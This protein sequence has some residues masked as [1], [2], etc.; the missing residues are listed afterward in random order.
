MEEKALNT[1]GINRITDAEL[2]E[3]A[4]EMTKFSYAPYSK[5]TVGTAL[6]AADGTVYTGCGKVWV[7]W[8]IE[9]NEFL[10]HIES[11]EGAHKEIILPNGEVL[12]SDDA[13]IDCRV[14]I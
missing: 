8:K 12:V 2:L 3:K 6:L 4:R 1:V 11:E 10:L 14:G 5:F 9:N 7:D 13:V